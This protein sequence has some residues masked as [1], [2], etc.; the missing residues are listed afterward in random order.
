MEILGML[1]G[2]D[3]DQ[4]VIYMGRFWECVLGWV[5]MRYMREVVGW[6]LVGGGNVVWGIW[7]VLF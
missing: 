1:E 7:L 6:H 2:V 4:G 3:Q 5:G